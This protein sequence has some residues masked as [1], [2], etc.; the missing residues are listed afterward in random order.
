MEFFIRKNGRTY[1]KNANPMVKKQ[2]VNPLH[3]RKLLAAGETAMQAYL[4]KVA[5]EMKRKGPFPDGDVKRGTVDVTGT[6]KLQGRMALRE[7]GG[8]IKARNAEYLAIPL[9]DA[10]GANGKP[11]KLTARHW[12]KAFVQK[13]AAG[14]LLLVQRRG[15]KLIPLYALKRYLHIKGDRAA[16]RELKAKRP[17]F[18][19]ELQRALRGMLDD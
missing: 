12:R 4:R 1:P 18:H 14:E 19:K 16:R 15:R 2:P 8:I 11:R 7:M 5:A 6:F 17:V 13:S 3:I 10:L 9:P